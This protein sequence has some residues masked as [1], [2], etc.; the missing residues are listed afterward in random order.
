MSDIR[1]LIGVQESKVVKF[2]RLSK[3]KSSK[4]KRELEQRLLQPEVIKPYTGQPPGPQAKEPLLKHTIKF[5]FAR[6]HEL[7]L[8]KRTLPVSNHVEMSVA[9]HGLLI[10]LL[11]EVDEGRISYDKKSQ[12]VSHKEPKIK[13]G[14]VSGNKRTLLQWRMSK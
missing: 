14:N 5:V 2:L 3:G 11:K 8:V 1:N 12:T 13:S 6:Q 7:D 4:E 10:A 9:N